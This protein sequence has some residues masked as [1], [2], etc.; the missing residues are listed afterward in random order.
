MDFKFLLIFKDPKCTYKQLSTAGPY[1][2]PM[3]NG[4]LALVHL[5]VQTTDQSYYYFLCPRMYMYS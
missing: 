3:M 2:G 5:T 1:A 4:I